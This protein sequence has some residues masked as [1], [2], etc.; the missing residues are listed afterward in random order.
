MIELRPNISHINR[1]LFYEKKKM[2]KL[3][4]KAMPNLILDT[5][6]STETK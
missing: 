6:K 5:K 2:F 1:Q 3:A 4:Y